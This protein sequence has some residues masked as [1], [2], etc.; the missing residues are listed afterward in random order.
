MSACILAEETYWIK[1]TERETGE[2]MSENNDARNLS[3][4]H[5]MVV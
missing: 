2:K 4:T 1:D 5:R 3:D